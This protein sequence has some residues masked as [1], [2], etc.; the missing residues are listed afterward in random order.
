MVHY[1]Y[2]K[3]LS[4]EAISEIVEIHNSIE[5]LADL[6]HLVPHNLVDEINYFLY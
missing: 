2:S 6:I 1:F 5:K 4:F 3:E